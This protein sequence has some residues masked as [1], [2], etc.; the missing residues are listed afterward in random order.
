MRLSASDNRPNRPVCHDLTPPYSDLCRLRVV[1]N[2]DRF[3]H[4]SDLKV[5]SGFINGVGVRHAEVTRDMFPGYKVRAVTNGIHAERWAHPAFAR[6]FTET[7]PRWIERPE[8]VFHAAEIRDEDVQL[9]KQAAKSQLIDFIGTTTGV[10]LK[11][12]IA[13]IGYA[14]RMTAYKRP[15]LIIEDFDRLRAIAQKYPI[16]LVFAGKAHPDD[17]E[18]SDVIKTI[19]GRMAELAEFVSIA[20]IPNYDT[21]SAQLL[22]S[23]SDIWLN[24][25]RPPLEASGTSGMKAALNGTLNLS[26][27][28]GW[29]VEGCVEGATGWAIGS[30]DAAESVEEHAGHLHAGHLYDKLENTVLPLYA[31][32]DRSKWTWMTKQ[33]ISKIGAYFNSHRMLRRYIEDAYLR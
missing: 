21:S 32:D 4:A 23:G 13:I 33:S 14:R 6:L 16:Q 31:S 24:T 27:L 15:S 17:A 9:A 11:P 20:F 30:G 5:L 25:P 2:L 19:Q 26:T 29:W 12:D 7:I 18:G 10:T 22:V 28:D 8:L 3:C 1:R